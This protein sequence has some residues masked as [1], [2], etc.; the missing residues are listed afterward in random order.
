MT[1][2]LLALIGGA[3]LLAL[4]GAVKGTL[5]HVLAELAR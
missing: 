4:I 3:L 1:L 5:P 2:A